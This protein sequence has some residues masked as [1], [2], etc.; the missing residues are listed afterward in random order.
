F[1]LFLDDDDMLTADS[2]SR[3]LDAIRE[4]K[5]VA[6]VG[7]PEIFNERGVYR[8]R[9]ACRLRAYMPWLDAVGGWCAL[10]GQALFRRRFLLDLGG[11]RLGTEPSE[12]QDLWMRVGRYPVTFIPERVVRVRSHIGQGSRESRN[13][14]ELQG[15]IRM[16]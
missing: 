10:Q 8:T 15:R 6:A 5:T 4:A 13:L 11:F 3:L 14:T 1:V 12:D 16:N 2:L 7:A 9:P